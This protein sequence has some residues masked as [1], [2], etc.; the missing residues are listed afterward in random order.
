MLIRATVIRAIVVVDVHRGM[1]YLQCTL[2]YVG[3]STV[4][5]SQHNLKCGVFLSGCFS[6]A[7]CL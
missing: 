2:L 6:F 5:G 7:G 3:S 1:G 4:C